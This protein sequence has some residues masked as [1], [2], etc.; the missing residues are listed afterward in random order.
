MD[1]RPGGQI[2]AQALN[3]S[4]L[5]LVTSHDEH[6]LEKGQSTQDSLSVGS[7]KSWPPLL[8][9]K[10]DRYLWSYFRL[11]KF[12]LSMIILP[13]FP[14]DPFSAAVT[15]APQNPVCVWPQQCSWGS[16]VQCGDLT[17]W[18]GRGKWRG[19]SCCLDPNG[20]PVC[21]TVTGGG[22]LRSQGPA[23]ASRICGHRCSG[24]TSSCI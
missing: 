12:I 21:A 9:K 10:R 4:V 20:A 11:T 18:P 15:L 19:S 17:Q 13:L 2:Q 1:S 8:G 24:L 7:L 3:H 6:C 16:W 5:S 23:C 14:L 22:H